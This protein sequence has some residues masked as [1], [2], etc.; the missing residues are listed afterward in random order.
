MSSP[1]DARTHGSGL[2][3]APRFAI[4]TTAVLAVVLLLFSVVLLGTTREIVTG[5]IQDTQDKAAVAQSGSLDGTLTY[6]QIGKNATRLK[7]S[8]LLRA[9]VDL[10]RAVSYTHLTLPTTPYV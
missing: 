1:R 3:I 4:A 8:K 10:L 2:G 9:E 7:G 5:A 6:K